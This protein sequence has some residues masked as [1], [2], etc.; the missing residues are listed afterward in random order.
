MEFDPILSGEYKEDGLPYNEFVAQFEAVTAL[1]EEATSSG[2]DD[3]LDIM[4]E[5]LAELKLENPNAV[6]NL[7]QARNFNLQ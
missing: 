4:S 7:P 5:R 2:N 1:V 3:L 6:R